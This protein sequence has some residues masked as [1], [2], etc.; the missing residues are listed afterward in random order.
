MV[1]TSHLLPQTQKS[2]NVPCGVFSES[3]FSFRSPVRPSLH[4]GYLPYSLKD[5]LLM[6]LMSAFEREALVSL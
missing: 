4:G 2:Q 3:S 1:G 6:E 5:F